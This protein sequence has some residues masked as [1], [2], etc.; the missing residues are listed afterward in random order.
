MPDG[1]P[2]G[3]PHARRETGATNLAVLALVC[4]L[5]LGGWN[6]YRNYQ[7]DLAN[8]RQLP[9]AGY[10]SEDLLALKAA[11]ASE[12]E[13]AGALYAESR[14]RLSAPSA[15]GGAGQGLSER[16]KA[17]ERS[18]ATADS[19]RRTRTD[20]A[21][22]QARLEE[23]DAELERRRKPFAAVWLHLERLFR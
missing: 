4:L 15:R 7:A 18:Q 10:S 14:A 13:S 16:V 3:L 6:Y 17:L 9:F 11:Y 5:G 19:I 12:S 20:L 8:P 23:V 21:H 22:N 1:S 2:D